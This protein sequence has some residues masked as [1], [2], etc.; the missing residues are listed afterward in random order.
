MQLGLQDP[1]KLVQAPCEAVAVRATP[2]YRTTLL[3][4]V[5]VLAT[6]ASVDVK[7]SMR[8]A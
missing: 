5:V 1:V 3:N 2:C 7:A 8:E 6:V 4:L